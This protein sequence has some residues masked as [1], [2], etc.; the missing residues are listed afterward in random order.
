MNTKTLAEEKAEGLKNLIGMAIKK[1]TILLASN[2]QEYEIIGSWCGDIV[3]SNTNI[4][5]DDILIYGKNELVDL[6]SMSVFYIIK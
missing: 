5:E 3:L 6:I 1:G 4:D 2:A